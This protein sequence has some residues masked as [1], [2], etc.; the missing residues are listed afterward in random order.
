MTVTFFADSSFL[1]GLMSDEDDYSQDANDLFE[2]IKENRLVSSISDFQISNYIIVEVIHNLIDQH[3]KISDI[4][5]HYEELKGCKTFH[6]KPRDIDYAFTNKL[7][8]F[9]NHRTQEPRIG[10]VD[11][12][13]LVVMEKKRI[14]YIISFDGDFKDLPLVSQISDKEGVDEKILIWHR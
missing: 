9:C 3:V 6:V 1:T 10:I 12:T 13:S 8:H 4:K 2:Y 7:A 5:R 14:N 11:A